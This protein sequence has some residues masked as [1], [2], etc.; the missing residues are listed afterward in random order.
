LGG[1]REGGEHEGGGGVSHG[2]L[3]GATVHGGGARAVEK[4]WGAREL[5]KIRNKIHSTNNTSAQNKERRSLFEEIKSCTNGPYLRGGARKKV[6]PT[7]TDI[8]AHIG[9]SS[10]YKKNGATEP[11]KAEYDLVG[12]SGGKRKSKSPAAEDI[13]RKSACKPSAKKYYKRARRGREG[14]PQWHR[15]RLG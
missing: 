2:G 14:K 9:K 4:M 8:G 15:G 3:T 13:D 7:K 1:G 11:G 12:Q 6:D 10:F 5:S